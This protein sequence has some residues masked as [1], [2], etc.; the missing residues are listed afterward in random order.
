M[1]EVKVTDEIQ[2]Q[3]YKLA[4]CVMRICYALPNVFRKS[5]SG[6]ALTEVGFLCSSLANHLLVERCRCDKR[7]RAVAFLESHKSRL[8][9]D[10]TA[11]DWHWMGYG[12]GVPM[13]ISTPAVHYD[14]PTA[15]SAWHQH[16]RS[17]ST[18]V[19]NWFPVSLRRVKVTSDSVQILMAQRIVV[20]VLV[21]HT[22]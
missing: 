2:V 7:R 18:L 9:L 8:S 11:S 5:V 4:F 12:R 21:S 14:S 1:Q 16:H 17:T 3:D 13:Q 6:K 20:F 15:A 10:F 22:R 19:K